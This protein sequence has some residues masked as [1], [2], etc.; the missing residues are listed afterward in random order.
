MPQHG[1]HGCYLEVDLT[2]ATSRRVRLDEEVL[3][4]YLGGVG[5]GAYLLNR[6]D[7]ADVD[8]LSPDAPLAFVFSPLVGSPLTT[9]A[10]F[11][12]VSKSPQTGRF[13]DSLASSSFAIAG[14]RI[15]ADAIVIVGRATKPTV[16]V[17]RDDDIQFRDASAYWGLECSAAAEAI[18]SGES[19]TEAQLAV[20]GPA[21][22]QRVRY[23]TISHDGRHAGR[24]GHGAV[25][26][27]KQLKG[28]A[29]EGT[30]RVQWADPQRLYTLSKALS[31]KSFGP[32]TAKYRELGTAANLLVFNRLSLLPTHNFQ[33]GQLDEAEQL[34]PELMEQ[35]Q[36]K[37]RKSC[38]ACTI[39]CEHLYGGNHGEPVRVEYE[40]LFALG[41]N[42]GIHVPD[43]VLEACRR[44]DALGMD[45]IS[46]GGTLA[47]AMNCAAEG[48][49]PEP[50]GF[51][52]GDA[53][54]RLL[55]QTARREGIGDDLA[56]GSRLMAARLGPRAEHL[57][58]HVKGLELPGYE[59]RGLTAMAVG[60]AVAARGAD[61]NRSGAYEADF[62]GDVQT[63]D[64]GAA[65]V[66]VVVDSEN[67]AAVMDSLILCKFVRGVFTDF[68]REAAEM[69]AAITGWDVDGDEL[70]E[71]AERIVA[72]RLHFNRRAGWTI[73]EDTLPPRMF[74]Q[75]VGPHAA[76]D[77]SAFDEAVRGYHHRRNSASP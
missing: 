48:L 18:R 32:A 38:A 70:R 69:L 28:I 43:V 30:Q 14:K 3:R 59:P 16:L 53:L 65:T 54:L 50:L 13:N 45:T 21:G 27:S 74:Q 24:G 66:D 23:A 33:D 4:G 60:L 7:R 44:C 62:A 63:G 72:A 58:T 17:I 15:G 55:E 10:K 11:S 39:G 40:S 73:A 46:F 37:T 1:Y 6:L 29:V 9:S 57:T 2:A 67:R 76:I 5:L 35:T 61:H 31:K 34:S 36:Q 64:F 51:G 56:D 71:T 41:A 12:V 47:F 25:M 22:E 77:R 20:I 19:L 49:W 8:P 26:G 42:C 68:Y 52:D 75:A